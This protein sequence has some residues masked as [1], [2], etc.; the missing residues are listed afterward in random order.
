[1]SNP[2]QVTR[3]FEKALCDYTGAKYAVALNSGTA[4][5]LLSVQWYVESMIR[6]EGPGFVPTVEIP[7]RTYVSV[8]CAIKQAGAKLEWRDE[9]WRGAYRLKPTLVWDCA[10]MFTSGMYVPTIFQCVSFAAAKILGAEQGGAILHDND[11]ADKW[12]RKMRFDGRTEGV[13]PLQD[14]FDVVGYH[15]IMIPSVAA[16]LLVRLH[17]LPKH[18]EDLGFHDYPD[19]SKHEAFR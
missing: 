3:D 4:A 5:I 19:L 7:R 12:F 8:P 14:T 6:L 9:D 11:E 2:Y 17:H 13:D 15:C 18:N 16:T 1:M 10:R